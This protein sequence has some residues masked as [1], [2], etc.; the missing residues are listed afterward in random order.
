MK[1]VIIRLTMI[2][3]LGAVVLL[4]ACHKA[5]VASTVPPPPPPTA[6]A[7]PPTAP[8]PP[9]PTKA[10]IALKAGRDAVTPQSLYR[11]ALMLAGGKPSASAGGSVP[12][13]ALR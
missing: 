9:P 2:L 10:E 6:P 8:E 13:A 12:G 4:S 7:P 1:H 5:K 3:T 11:T